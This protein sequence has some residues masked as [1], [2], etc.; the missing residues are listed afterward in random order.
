M[1]HGVQLDNGERIEASTVVW[2]VGVK[3]SALTQQIDGERDAFGRLHVDR[4]LKV[5]GQDAIYATGDTSYA[6]VDDLGNH[7]RQRAENADQHP[8]DLPAGGQARDRP[9]C[10]RPADSGSRLIDEACPG[11][12]LPWACHAQ[13]R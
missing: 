4:N 9:G 1:S 3:A 12:W 11:R 5:L 13:S 6:A 2:T 8:V 10:S 7:G